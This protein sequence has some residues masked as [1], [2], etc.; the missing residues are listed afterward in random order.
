MLRITVL[1]DPEGTRFKLEGKLA[2]AWVRE[3]EKAWVALSAINGK[4]KVIV[5]LFG[6]TFVDDFGRQLLTEMCHAGAELVG[7]GPMMAALIEQIEE[8][9]TARIEEEPGTMRSMTLEELA[10]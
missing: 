10:Q 6:V 8:A 4:K 9:E 1:N 5:D 7:S 2:Q 3:A